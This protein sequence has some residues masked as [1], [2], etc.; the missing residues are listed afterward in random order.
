MDVT[1]GLLIMNEQKEILVAHS[2]GNKF[3]DLPKGLRDEGE[4]SLQAVLRE[5]DE[6]TGLIFNPHDLSYLGEHAYNSKKRIALFF[7]AVKKEDID[8]S[9]L[10]CRSMFE[11][12]LSK[13]MLPEAD[14][15]K[16][17]PFTEESIT[18]NCTKSMIKVL[19]RFLKPTDWSDNLHLW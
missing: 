12:P 18:E 14:D 9:N 17:I 19:Q 11:H 15:F 4:T 3:W 16:W 8:M 6:E 13:K 5:C 10:I 7:V 1:C 2:T